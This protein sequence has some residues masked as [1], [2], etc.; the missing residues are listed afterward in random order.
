MKKLSK[1]RRLLKLL[2]TK[3]SNATS[4][5]SMAILDEFEKLID[6]KPHAIT[7]S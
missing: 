5:D 7:I 4:K 2:L 3:E 6:K 1:K